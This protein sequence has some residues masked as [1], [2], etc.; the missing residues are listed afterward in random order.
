MSKMF[1]CGSFGC[2][3]VTIN[4]DAAQKAEDDRLRWAREQ[5]RKTGEFPKAKEQTAFV[6]AAYQRYTQ[7]KKC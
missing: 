6:A 4:D 1:L 3:M 2:R 5:K 7:I